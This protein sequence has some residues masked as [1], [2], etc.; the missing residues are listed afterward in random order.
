MLDIWQFLSDVFPCNW[1]SETLHNLGNQIDW[2][3]T[4]RT[5]P[6]KRNPIRKLWRPQ[7]HL[8]PHCMH[9][10]LPRARHNN[11]LDFLGRGCDA[12]MLACIPEALCNH[13]HGF[14]KKRHFRKKA[15]PGTRPK[16]WIIT[17]NFGGI[18]V[19]GFAF[20]AINGSRG[21]TILLP[22]E[23]LPFEKAIT[24]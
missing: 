11:P 3:R 16:S 22:L 5:L 13:P 6:N 17:H 20:W 23:T 21:V 14:G 24:S 18:R 4:W 10:C 2:L 15:S 7:P 8:F 19:A 12:G 1:Y 9:Q